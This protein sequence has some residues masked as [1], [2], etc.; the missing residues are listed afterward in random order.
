LLKD[1]KSF[2]SLWSTDNFS[3]FRGKNIKRSNSFSVR[4]FSHVECLNFGRIV[5]KNDWSMENMVAKISFMLRWQ[6]DSPIDL[7]LE[8]N[9]FFNNLQ[10]LNFLPF[11]E[12]QWLQCM[13][14]LQMV[15]L[16]ICLSIQLGLPF[17]SIK[18]KDLLCCFIR[19]ILCSIG[20]RPK[21]TT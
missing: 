18:I 14:L 3:Y 6:I 7:I 8:D 13:K 12:C 9:S 19:Q 5:I 17:W 21:R 20:H 15:R 1:F 10:L 16:L 11:I 4:V 2:L